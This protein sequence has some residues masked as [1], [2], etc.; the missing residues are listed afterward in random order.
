LYATYV[1]ITAPSHH[2]TGHGVTAYA[3][4]K[5]PRGDHMKTMYRKLHEKIEDDF[6][7]YVYEVS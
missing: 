2:Y 1:S 4:Y 3:G 7:K 5:R 6:T